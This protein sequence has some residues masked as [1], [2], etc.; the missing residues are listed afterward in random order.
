M[1]LFL[2]RSR[3]RRTFVIYLN[4]ESAHM[5]NSKRVFNWISLGGFGKE[6]VANGFMLIVVS[7]S[8]SARFFRVLGKGVADGSVL[9]CTY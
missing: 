8:H 6:G 1:M 5:A 2:Y 4:K 7:V 3:Y 9:Q